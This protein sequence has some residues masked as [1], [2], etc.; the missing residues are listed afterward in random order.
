MK[1]K[2]YYMAA[3]DPVALAGRLELPLDCEVL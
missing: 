3:V 1:L 2:G